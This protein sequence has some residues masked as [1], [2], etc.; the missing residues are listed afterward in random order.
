VRKVSG[1][2]NLIKDDF[3]NATSS[4]AAP[5]HNYSPSFSVPQYHPPTGTIP[6]QNPAWTI[7]SSGGRKS[8]GHKYKKKSD[9]PT[10]T[11]EPP[12]SA[13]WSF[14][15]MVQSITDVGRNL[16]QSWYKT[17]DDIPVQPVIERKQLVSNESIQ[18]IK[19]LLPEILAGKSH[20]DLTWFDSSAIK[21]VFQVRSIANVVFK[22]SNDPGDLHRQMDN[23]KKGQQVCREHSFDR[24]IIPEA[25]LVDVT[26]EIGT[27]SML[28]QEFIPIE[29]DPSVLEKQY[30]TL[31]EADEAIRQLALFI[32]KTGFSDV[33]WRNIPLIYDPI[34]GWRIAL[35]DLDSM[36]GARYGIFG[37]HFNSARGLLRCLFS[38]SQIAICLAIAREYQIKFPPISDLE[39]T[40]SRLR[41][42]EYQQKLY[43][44]YDERKISEHSANVPIDVDITSLGLNLDEVKQISGENAKLYGLNQIAMKEV[45][46]DVIGKINQ[47]L[48]ESPDGKSL[49][50]KRKITLIS[51]SADYT[52]N[53][54]FLYAG[55]GLQPGRSIYGN[56]EEFKQTWLGR[57]LDALVDKGYLFNR[58][59][60]TGSEYTLQA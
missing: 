47:A 15:S 31:S 12:A 36:D 21:K 42:R 3:M 34:Y 4:L 13:T 58:F 49:Q 19:R 7:G 33:D 17:A 55:I 20:P 50:A 32:I 27:V 60:A 5:H 16:L 28:A 41:D 57:I 8:D 46:I 30:L 59:E 39:I 14:S 53:R 37:G 43:A 26:G 51:H 22:I 29:K 11:H 48:K 18:E 9:T 54:L 44:F 56:E 38:E 2:N 1:N 10:A 25:S 40:K 24:L 6:H 35:I 23:I 52:T 45:V